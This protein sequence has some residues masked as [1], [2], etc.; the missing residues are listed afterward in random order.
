MHFLFFLTSY[1]FIFIFFLALIGILGSFFTVGFF[2]ILLINWP[3]FLLLFIIFSLVGYRRRKKFKVLDSSTFVDGRIV[4]LIR[5]EFLEGPFL[6]PK[7]IISELHRL[8][9]SDNSQRRMKGRRALD[10]IAEIQRIPNI[11]V[12]IDRKNYNIRDVDTKLVKL[13][14]K[15]KSVLV[16]T[17][18]NLTKVAEIESIKVLNLNTLSSMIKRIILPNEELEIELLKKGDKDNQAI[19]YLEDGTMVVISNAGNKVGNKV[20]VLTTTT[21]PTQAGRII[22]GKL[23]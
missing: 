12:I 7:F 10:N 4:E 3:L 13:T 22:F 15:R 2:S 16:T 20:K 11:D 8:S 18:F 17:D 14:K 21:Y 19:G 1:L 23:K 5:S 9:D 6:I